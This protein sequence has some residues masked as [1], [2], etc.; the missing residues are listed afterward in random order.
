VTGALR[1]ARPAT[2][3]PMAWTDRAVV[4]YR[5]WPSSSTKLLPVTEALASEQR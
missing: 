1:P 2:V 3:G 5:N 4:A